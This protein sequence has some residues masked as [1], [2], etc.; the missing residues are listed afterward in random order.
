[1][2]TRGHAVVVV[3]LVASV[4]PVTA[5]SAAQRGRPTDTGGPRARSGRPGHPERVEGP[6]TGTESREGADHPLGLGVPTG[7]TVALQGAVVA[8][9]LPR[10]QEP[11][12]ATAATAPG[13]RV[14][15]SGRLPEGFSTTK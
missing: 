10:S 12:S 5:L 2:R 4:A 3:L 11:G 9:P 1:M 13:R 15:N 6:P 14:P 7:E 8:M